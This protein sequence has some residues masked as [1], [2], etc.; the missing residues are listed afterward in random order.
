MAALRA[1]AGISST[2]QPRAFSGR[3]VLRSSHSRM[4][5][6]A[7][8]RRGPTSLRS[9]HAASGSGYRQAKW[10]HGMRR[11]YLHWFL[12]PQRIDCAR[13]AWAS[14][15]SLKSAGRGAPGPDVPLRT[16]ARLVQDRKTQARQCPPQQRQ[17]AQKLENPEKAENVENSETNLLSLLL[18]VLPSLLFGRPASQMVLLGRYGTVSGRTRPDN[19]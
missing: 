13:A 9:H 14:A 19:A 11:R 18:P 2:I 7:P 1:S 16:P 8:S 3:S 10:P 4:W 12:S 17:T 6:S 5:R 15:A